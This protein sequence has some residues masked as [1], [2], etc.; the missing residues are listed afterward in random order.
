MKNNLQHLF[1]IPVPKDIKLF[2][3]G[4][5]HEHLNQ[6]QQIIKKV[7]PSNKIWFVSVGDIFDKGM[8]ISTAHKITRQLIEF[9]NQ[10]FGFAVKGNHEIKYLN[11]TSPKNYS[12]ELIWWNKQPGILHFEFENNNLF[13]IVHAGINPNISSW[14]ELQY[15]G[16]NYY[17]RSIDENGE[18]IPLHR[19]LRNGI[20][21]LEP[22]KPNGVTWHKSYDGRF[23][24]V[25]AGH[26]AQKDGIPKFYKNSCN[27]DTAVFQ[28]GKLTGVLVG[29]N[30]IEEVIT[31]EGKPV[32]PNYRI[33]DEI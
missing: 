2:V 15:D 11:R 13:T 18:F 28:T 17:I 29:K 33:N 20:I 32:N 23:G 5:L 24:Y 9:D 7:Q 25:I 14:E 4:D 12:P 27:I 1:Y 8:G 6:F 22:V 10:E 31:I 30:G 26:D 3:V 16:R 21:S 19:V